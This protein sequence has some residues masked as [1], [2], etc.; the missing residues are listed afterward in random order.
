MFSKEDFSLYFDILE[1]KEKTVGFLLRK[2]R[3]KV[4]D[5]KVIAVLDE[6]LRGDFEHYKMAR[7]LFGYLFKEQVERRATPREAVLTDVK[8]KQIDSGKELAGGCTDISARG[9]EIQTDKIL[10]I[11]DDL[12]LWISV[13][14]G[15]I[16]ASHH[17][18]TV[19][20]VN[21]TENSLF[22][23]YKAGVRFVTAQHA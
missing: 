4:S 16:R 22:Q 1:E 15:R 3:Q 5:A 19:I 10:K 12:E 7:Q 13:D 11:G 9:A 18:A 8:I 6:I 21:K 14:N 20:W 23:P 17:R 2:L